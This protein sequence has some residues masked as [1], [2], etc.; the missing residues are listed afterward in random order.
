MSEQVNI[1]KWTDK[2]GNLLSCFHSSFHHFPSSAETGNWNLALS[3]TILHCWM[4]SSMLT[5]TNIEPGSGSFLSNSLHL[6]CS[7]WFPRWNFLSLGRKN[8]PF[9]LPDYYS[10]WFWLHEQA[11]WRNETAYFSL[12]IHNWQSILSTMFV[13]NEIFSLNGLFFE[14]N[15]CF[16]TK[17]PI[18][19]KLYFFYY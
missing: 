6:S 15:S 13:F 3:W 18:P 19:V 12:F 11:Y 5:E 10:C 14:V 16:L 1:R 8:S 7:V 9:P 2:P 4:T 17:E